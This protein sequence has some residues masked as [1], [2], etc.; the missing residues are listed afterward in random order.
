MEKEIQLDGNGNRIRYSLF[1][2]D[3][4]ISY[5]SKIGVKQTEPLSGKVRETWECLRYRFYKTALIIY[6]CPLEC[7]VC[8]SL[9]FYFQLASKQLKHFPPSA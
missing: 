7:N 4:Q 6:L 8:F 9:F 2:S 3:G 5:T 1:Q